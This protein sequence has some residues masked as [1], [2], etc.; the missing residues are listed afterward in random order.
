MWL[1]CHSHKER[2]TRLPMPVDIRHTRDFLGLFKWQCSSVALSL[3]LASLLKLSNSPALLVEGMLRKPLACLCSQVDCQCSSCFLLVQSLIT[4]LATFADMPKAGSAPTSGHEKQ[5]LANWSAT[6]FPSIP[7][8]P[9]NHAN[10]ILLCSASFTRNW[11]Q[12]QTSLECS[13]KPL[14]TL[15][16]T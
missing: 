10:H 3:L 6:S 2:A 5:C 11:W 16:A 12:F 9:G 4:P 8:F 14:R 7:M 15:M 1:M 13:W